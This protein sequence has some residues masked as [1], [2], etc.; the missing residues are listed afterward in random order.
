MR[1]VNRQR[2]TATCAIT[3]LALL[4]AAALIENIKGDQ[5]IDP[6]T[7]CITFGIY[8]SVRSINAYRD[9]QSDPA[10]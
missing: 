3:G 2:W 7:V 1:I 6:F 10:E 8:L 9:E 4:G 5:W